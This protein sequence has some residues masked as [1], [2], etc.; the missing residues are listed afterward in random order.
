[1]SI[2]LYYFAFCLPSFHL[3]RS[4]IILYIFQPSLSEPSH[5]PSTFLHSDIF[6]GSLVRST[7]SKHLNIFPLLPTPRL[8]SYLFTDIRTRSFNTTHLP[9]IYFRFKT[10]NVFDRGTAE[11]IS[12]NP[13]RTNMIFTTTCH[14]MNLNN[15]LFYYNYRFFGHYSSSC[16]LFRLD[17]VSVL[18]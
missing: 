17:Y 16:F 8:D 14:P 10:L 2:L 18:R 9:L 13:S 15:Q 6:L 11:T 5:V 4:Q 1:M 12:S 3:Q 7:C